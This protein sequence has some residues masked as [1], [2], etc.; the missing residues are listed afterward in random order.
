MRFWLFSSNRNPR[1]ETIRC[2]SLGV[3][4]SFWDSK[5]GFFIISGGWSG[6]RYEGFLKLSYAPNANFG[7]RWTQSPRQGFIWMYAKPTRNAPCMLFLGQNFKL[8]QKWSVFALNL[9]KTCT[10]GR[11]LGKMSQT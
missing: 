3:L 6:E 4:M 7:P 9:H 5:Y 2:L 11:F 1:N 10:S 8:P